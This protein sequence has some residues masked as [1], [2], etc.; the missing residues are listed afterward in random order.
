MRLSIIIPTYNEAATIGPLVRYLSEHGGDALAGI[1]VSDG[2]ST[3]DTGALA[4]AA[5]AVVLQSPQKGRAA[6]MNHGAALAAGDVLYFVHADTFP[7]PTY[8]AD[9]RRA[10]EKGYDLGRYRTRF[11][12]RKW[13]L[14]LNAWFTR[15]DLFICMG[16]D[17]TLF[18]RKPLFRELGGFRSEMRIMEEYEFCTRAR[19]RGRYTILNDCALVSAR[20]YDKNSWLSVQRANYA[21]VQRYRNGASQEELVDE[22]RRRLNW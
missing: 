11:D 17:Q 20:K 6:Q 7:P 19:A 3:D 12:S 22:Y 4:A 2:G 10:L 21:V 1:T 16:G 5:G 15:F 14:R 13:L 9:I 8:V 18:I